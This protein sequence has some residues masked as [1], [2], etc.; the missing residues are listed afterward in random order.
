M[1][2]NC[3]QANVRSFPHCLISRLYYGAP[4][5]WL[6]MWIVNF[7][8]VFHEWHP[9]FLRR[10]GNKWRPACI[11]HAKAEHIAHEISLANEAEKIHEEM[12]W[13]TEKNIFINRYAVQFKFEFHFGCRSVGWPIFYF[14]FFFIVAAASAAARRC[15][16]MIGKRNSRLTIKC[17]YR[18]GRVFCRFNCSYIQIWIYRKRINGWNRDIKYRTRRGRARSLIQSYWMTPVRIGSWVVTHHHRMV[19]GLLGDTSHYTAHTH[20]H[21]LNGDNNNNNDSTPSILPSM[22]DCAARAIMY[23]YVSH[24]IVRGIYISLCVE[25]I[26]FFFSSLF[27]YFQMFSC[28]YLNNRI[29]STFYAILYASCSNMRI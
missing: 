24:G 14:F 7:G 13:K 19:C 20:T 17:S 1:A 18:D 23:E 12:V 8:D 27:Q 21:T 28:W 16:W 10:W 2:F 3:Q 22:Y 5:C 4:I 15:K 25:R 26:R 6:S 29:L 9:L 11:P